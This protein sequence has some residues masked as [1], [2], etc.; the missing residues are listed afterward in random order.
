MSDSILYKK[1]YLVVIPPSKYEYEYEM[2]FD[3]YDMIF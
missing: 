1:V 2:Y 3:T